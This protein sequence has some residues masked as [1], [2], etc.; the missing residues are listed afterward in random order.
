VTHVV[1][2]DANPNVKLKATRFVYALNSSLVA[3][4][5][6][7]EWFDGDCTGQNYMVTYAREFRYDS[8]R[9]RYLNRQLDP[10]KL[11]PDGYPDDLVSLS[12][13]WSDYDGDTIYGDFTI[14]NNTVTNARSFEPGIAKHYHTD[15]IGSTRL[16]T[17]NTG[18]TTATPTYTAFG[19]RVDTGPSERFAYAGSWGYESHDFP[20]GSEIPYLHVGF[21]YYDPGSGRFLQRDP[22]GIRGGLNVYVYV[23]NHPVSFIDPSGLL[24]PPDGL[25][26]EIIYR[27]KHKRDTDA[28]KVTGPSPKPLSPAQELK[29]VNKKNAIITYGTGTCGAA[30][31]FFIPVVGQAIGAGVAIGLGLSYLIDAIEN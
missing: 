11:T 29:R 12:D 10:S 6:G 9:G 27:D 3:Y 20:Q 30:A 28:D 16:L 18:S 19:E 15:Q 1:T 8:P 17:D 26:N 2:R 7:E 23:A 31:A 22:I 4:V 13:T 5:L 21:R 25:T 14:A 24:R